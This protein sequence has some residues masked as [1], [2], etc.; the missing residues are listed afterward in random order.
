MK[1]HGSSI[2]F[3]EER[4]HDLYRQYRRCLANV[5][6]IRMNEIFRMVVDSPAPRFYVSKIHA[7]N[8]ISC[9]MR[10][11]PLF[12]MR[13]PKREMFEEILR[14]SNILRSKH[15]DWT[16][17]DIVEEVIWQPAPKFYLS[18]S[19]AKIYINRLRKNICKQSLKKM[20]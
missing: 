19:S 7:T 5:R 3:S 9:L 14:R 18:P 13:G 16:L 2:D 11:K 12:K 8:I 10:G 1:P 4:A 17:S 15:P 20:K 6:Y